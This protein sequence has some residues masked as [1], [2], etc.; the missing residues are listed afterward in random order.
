MTSLAVR[1]PATSANLG[2]GF[3]V[4]GMAL[5][6]C[7]TVALC[8]IGE[9][10]PVSDGHPAMQ[11]FVRA[12]GQGSLW[13]DSPIPSGRGL[14][15]SGA[16]R[17]GGACLGLAQNAGVVAKDLSD[18]IHQHQ[19]EI[20][21]VAAELEGHFDNVAASVMG[22]IVAASPLST[23]AVPVASEVLDH[24][25]VVAWVP[26][27]QTST[28]TSRTTLPADI[29]RADAIFNIARSTQLVIALTTGDRDLLRNSMSDRL[30]QDQRLVETP[31]CRAVFNRMLE[32][33]AI[34]SWLSG[35]GPTVA[36]FVERNDAAK[37]AELLSQE[38][39]D[40]HAKVLSIDRLGLRG[41]TV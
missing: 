24:L 1:V 29:S 28:A 3:D 27:F 4:L 34:S 10:E 26:F 20:I 33:G 17:V 32:M 23:V 12:G 7:A 25:Q 30:H 15:F 5:S 11:A 13:V 16:V 14:G 9:T 36:A 19:S 31:Q 38:F 18:F 21:G 40:G 6:L 22:G 8:P 39:P 35:S 2:P 37:I 41:I